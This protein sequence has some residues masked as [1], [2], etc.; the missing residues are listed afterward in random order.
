M[1]NPAGETRSYAYTA[2]GLLVTEVD[3]LGRTAQI[4]YDATGRVVRQGFGDGREVV[5]RYDA[6]GELLGLTPPGQPEHGFAY[7]LRGREEGEV[8]GLT[9]SS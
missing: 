9:G 2:E 8:V 6:V 4:A 1:T 5:F 3:P 7:S